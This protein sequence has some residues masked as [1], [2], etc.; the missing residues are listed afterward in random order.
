MM[1]RAAGSPLDFA[2][3]SQRTTDFAPAI[4]AFTQSVSLS[5]W[6]AQLIRQK[7]WAALSSASAGD[8]S[9][10]KIAKNPL[11]TRTTCTM[12]RK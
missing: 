3:S 12:G 10:I 1:N 5:G 9:T 11:R 8:D 7:V 2:Q 4:W 6:L